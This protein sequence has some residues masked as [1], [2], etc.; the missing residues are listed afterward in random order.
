MQCLPQN[1][2]QRRYVLRFIPATILYVG[3]LL[4]AKIAFRHHL[5]NWMQYVVAVLPALPIIGMMA[6]VGIYLGEET[7]EFE[8]TVMVQSMLW[9]IA[10]TL[11]VMTVWG[12]LETFV[13]VEHLDD[14][15]SFPMFW[16][17]VALVTPIIRRRYR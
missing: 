10:G 7:D 12:F 2:A 8:K 4:L 5:S 6:I 3:L 15:M 9:S 14:Y 13:H 1:A 11:A 16:V 17:F